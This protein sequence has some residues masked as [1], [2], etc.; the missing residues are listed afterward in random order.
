MRSNMKY[1]LVGSPGRLRRWAWLVL[2]L[3]FVFSD[4]FVGTGLTNSG[5]GLPSLGASVTTV[6]A[7]GATSWLPLVTQAAKPASEP[8]YLPD[9]THLFI[10]DYLIAAR[11]NVI[12]IVNPPRRV[13]TQPLIRGLEPPSSFNNVNF[14]SDVAYDPDT[15]KFQIWYWAYDTLTAERYIA[16]SDSNDGIYWSLP[17]EVAG[18]RDNLF[19]AVLDQGTGVADPQHRYLAI[20]TGWLAPRGLGTLL[21]SPDGLD[22]KPLTGRPIFSNYYG[23]IW[24]PFYNVKTGKLGILHRWN[25]PYTWQDQE[26]ITHT[27]TIHDPSLVRL[28]AYSSS[29]DFLSF[30]KPR[31]IFVPDGKDSGETQFYSISNIVRRGGYYLAMLSVL[32]DD[33]KAD[34]TPEIFDS[35]ILKKS[36]PIYGTGYTVLAWSRDGEQWFRDRHTAP[37]FEPDPDPSQWDHA[38]AWGTSIVPVDDWVYIYYGGYRYGHKVYVDR[39]IGLARMPRDR[40]V[41]QVAF[42]QPGILITPLVKFDASSMTLNVAAAAGI[43]RVQFL[44][45]DGASIPGFTTEDCTFIAGED[46]LEAPVT[47]SGNLAKLSG[48][49]IQIVF[50]L[51]DAQ[52]FGFTL[53]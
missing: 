4:T 14:S 9:G 47:C 31:L 28:F 8:I 51:Q 48:R 42:T 41:G 6:E 7:A 53:N 10:D 43:V 29:R 33:L 22:W 39:Q 25:K 30:T 15:G 24:R 38:V 18:T 11:R 46:Q 19:T 12:R 44:D 23:E 40:Y 52:L 21:T 17:V 13:R 5:P 27:N 26:G 45:A 20:S 35:L 37:F 49:P 16:H 50:H 2:C 32:R 3:A 1:S 34:E 36:Y